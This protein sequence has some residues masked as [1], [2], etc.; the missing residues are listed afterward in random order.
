MFFA[1]LREKD[2]DVVTPTARMPR[3]P[4]APL[5]GK[6]HAELYTTISKGSESG[7]WVVTRWTIIEVGDL[8]PIVAI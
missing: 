6:I 3:P 5:C 4:L 8:T 1:F 7:G 2:F